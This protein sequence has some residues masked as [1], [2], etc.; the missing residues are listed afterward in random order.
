MN[1]VLFLTTNFEFL[2][3]QQILLYF[4]NIGKK[5]RKNFFVGKSEILCYLLFSKIL[6]KFIKNKTTC[7][8]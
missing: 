1:S 8:N 5:I 6:L 2:F 4:W 3:D 7:N